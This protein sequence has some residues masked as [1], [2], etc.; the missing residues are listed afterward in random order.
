MPI[1]LTVPVVRQYR[2]DLA[3]VNVHEVI[4]S[5]FGPY[6]AIIHKFVNDRGYGWCCTFASFYSIG[7]CSVKR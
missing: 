5:A 1:G 6:S 7:L 3:H 4:I 2:P